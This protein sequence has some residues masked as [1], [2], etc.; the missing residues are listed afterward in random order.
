MRLLEKT[1]KNT[2]R[3]PFLRQVF[4]DARFI[5]LYREPREVLA[6]M[7]EAWQSGRFRTYAELPGWSGL[8][9]SLLL[10]PGW[11]ELSGRPLEEVVAHQWLTTTNILLDDLQALPATQVV[12]LRY[13]DLV[14]SPRE[15]VARLCARLDIPWD[16]TLDE[17]PLSRHT[18]T[19][20]D[21]DKW[22]KHELALT[23][24]LPSVAAT[25]ARAESFLRDAGV[26][27]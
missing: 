25:Q 20:P 17:L 5:Y 18:L 1:P 23:R 10:V 12:P 27:R 11:R 26:D 14:A 4:P 9:W 7:I 6:S 2:L 24:V 21:P 8:P 19:P 22:R 3:L 13:A 15:Q 16:L